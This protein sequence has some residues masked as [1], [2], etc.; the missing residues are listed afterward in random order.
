MAQIQRLY[1]KVSWA[2]EK[3]FLDGIVDCLRDDK[4]KMGIISYIF[5]QDVSRVQAKAH[6]RLATNYLIKNRKIPY[7]QIR[8]VF[9]SYGRQQIEA[10][11]STVYDLSR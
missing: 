5:A 4:E 6:V 9:S 3:K 7:N 10:T 2:K 11:C 8:V 1:G